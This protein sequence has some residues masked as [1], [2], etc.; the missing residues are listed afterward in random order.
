MKNQYLGS[1]L[2]KKG[3][4]WTVPDLRGNLAKKDGVMFFTGSWGLNAHYELEE[5]SYWHNVL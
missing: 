1:E 5:P 3:G 2:A 4:A